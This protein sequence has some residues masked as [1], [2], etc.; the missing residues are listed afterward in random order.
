MTRELS[1][2]CSF[3]FAAVLLASCGPGPGSDGRASCASTVAGRRSSGTVTSPAGSSIA[4]TADTFE[5]D[6]TVT[7]CV[8]LGARVSHQ[9]SDA[10][11]IT[12]SAPARSV[13]SV[14]LPID[15]GASAVAVERSASS[16]APFERIAASP[17]TERLATF[18]TSEAGLYRAVSPVD[19]LDAG[20]MPIVDADLVADDVNRPDAPRPIGPVVVGPDLAPARYDCLGG[21]PIGGTGPA[22]DVEVEVRGF[23]DAVP[24]ADASVIVASAPRW[25]APVDCATCT[26]GTTDATGHVVLSLPPGLQWIYVGAGGASPTVGLTPLWIAGVPLPLG[27]RALVVEGVAVRDDMTIHAL[28]GGFGYAI[29]RVRDCDG[30]P[31]QRAHVRIFDDVTHTEITV[32][33]GGAPIRYGANGS[34]PVAPGDRTSADGSY[35]ATA[36]FDTVDLRVEAWGRRAVGEPDVLLGCRT[37]TF[38]DG[39]GVVADLFPLAADAGARCGSVP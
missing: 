7:L 8:A 24:R 10:Y 28:S 11:V 33:S 30:M 17:V 19:D 2:A 13:F 36:L 21:D 6:T 18:R 25:D 22:V 23:V 4:F 37:V 20:P 16:G 31:V 5:D 27:A 39:I 34:L 15:A 9:L 14:S 32:T 12:L 29:G 3:V 1:S 35:L 26:G 38:R